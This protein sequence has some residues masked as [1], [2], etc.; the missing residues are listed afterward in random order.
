[1]T[2]EQRTAG[3]RARGGGAR[4]RTSSRALG[5]ASRLLALLAS[6]ALLAGAAASPAAAAEADEPAAVSVLSPES[7][8][9]LGSSLDW[10]VDSAAAQADRLGRS[11]AVLE[12]SAPLPIGGTEAAYL[13]QFLRQAE[14]EGALAAITLRPEGDLADFGRGDAEQAVAALARARAGEALPLFVRFAPDMNSTWVSWGQRPEEYVA[15]FRIFAR[16]LHDDLPDA[17][18]VWSPT[19]GGAYPFAPAAPADSAALDT[20]G[21]GLLGPGDDPYRPYYP[22]DDVVDRVGLA[23]YHDPSGG[24]APRNALPGAG[25]LAAALSGP[26]GAGDLDFYGEY[27]EATGTPLLLE[28]AAFYSPGAGGP[29]EL[30]VKQA[31]WRQ[32]MAAASDEAYPLLDV[33]LWRDS[34]ATRPVV[35]EVVID[36]RVSG[37]DEIAAAFAA[38]VE[39][40]DL[41]PGPVYAPFT[42]S[43]LGPATGGTISGTAA[44]I[45]VALT[46]LVAAGATAWG[47][48][49]RRGTALSYDGPPSR[50]LRI[51]LLRGLAVVFVVVNHL[52]LVSIW[53]NATQEAIGMVSGAELFVLL[54]CAV[55]GLVHRPKV[56]GGGI[57]EVT[58]RTGRRA[59][60][61]YLTALVVTLVVGLVS[62]IDAVRS[63][64]ATTYIDEGTGAAGSEATGRVYDLYENIG[65]LLRYPA[66]PSIV[67]DLA[68]LRLGPWQV[69]ILGLYVVMLAV[70]PLILWALSRRRWLPVL[71][72]SWA[73]YAVQAFL[74]LRVLPS[75]FEDSFPLLSWQALFV[76]GVVA[77]FHRREI[78]AWF[79]TRLGRIVLAVCVMATA[80]LA[81]LS[82]N[83]PY[84]SST[85]DLRLGLVPANTFAEVYSA[86]FERTTLDPGRVLNV[87]LV[88]VTGYAA[89]TV[90]WRPIHRLIGWFLVPLGQ[91]TLYVFVMHVA[92]V[93]VIANVP[94]LREGNPVV[95]SLAYVLV[96]GLL[97]LMVRTRF[98]FAVV[99]R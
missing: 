82:W 71:L 53:Q 66:D 19:A 32:V 21:D 16:V 89:L 97:W 91:A 24:G 45:V 4:R 85:F 49:R 88:V 68:A 99:P 34:A 92:F 33:V 17:V 35:G 11:S 84:L 87:L 12:H 86:A 52:A 43:A 48:S 58:L 74:R 7:G 80:G 62:L 2:N 46:L 76:T 96:L 65:S 63:T 61:L 90:L 60:T 22:G 67:V 40:S 23:A 72:V 1:M 98:L 18:V 31:W 69:N 15:A 77:G 56:L 36:W 25:E 47:L 42:G 83:N 3:G 38:D 70:S 59:V 20:D 81:I 79:A 26:G 44:W 55:L 5:L 28:T 27:A 30:A 57:G 93:L 37:S 64:P 73:V 14:G 75:Q 94:I 9:Y 78:V 41:V 51:D 54:S 50:D 29:E 39:S 8:A 6:A 95:N 13:A 10:S